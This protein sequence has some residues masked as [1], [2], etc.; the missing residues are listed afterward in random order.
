MIYHFI[1]GKSLAQTYSI[2]IIKNYLC[3]IDY[4]SKFPVIKKLEGLSAKNLNTTTKIIFAEYGTPQKI[5]SDTGTNFVSDRFQQFCNTINV[6][7]AVS[8]AYHHQ[9]NGQVKACIKFIKCTFKKCADSGEDI[10]MALLQIHTTP[11]YQGLPSPATI[12]F[13]RPVCGIMPVVYCKPIG[14]D[15]DDMHHHKLVDRQQKNNNDASSD[16][17]IYPHRGNC[18]HPARRQWTMDSL[19]NSGHWQP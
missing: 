17:C 13:N 12:M 14:Q 9:S 19:D 1:H 6:E 15:C 11:L 8:Q 3:I 18:S 10:N 16:F 7:Q 4:N 2:L 5:I